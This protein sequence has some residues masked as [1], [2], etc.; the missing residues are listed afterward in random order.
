MQSPDDVAEAVVSSHNLRQANQLMISSESGFPG[1][2]DQAIKVPPSIKLND[3][4]SKADHE[5]FGY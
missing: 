4:E 5:N 2:R 3:L 1:L